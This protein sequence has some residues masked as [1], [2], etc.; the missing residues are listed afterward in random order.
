MGYKKNTSTTRGQARHLAHV[1]GVAAGR[2]IRGGCPEH[3][4]GAH[5][6]RGENQICKC[7]K[8]HSR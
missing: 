3:S 1:I 8:P 4:D 2:Q 7:G 5:R 6:Y